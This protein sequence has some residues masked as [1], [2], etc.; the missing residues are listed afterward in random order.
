MVPAAHIYST[1]TPS[2]VRSLLVQER[3]AHRLQRE[4]VRASLLLCPRAAR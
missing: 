4:L 3:D 2:R 1:A